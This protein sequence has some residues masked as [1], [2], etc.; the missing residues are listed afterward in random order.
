MLKV[1]AK[2]PPTSIH[3]DHGFTM[4]EVLIAIMVTTFFV[5]AALQAMAINAMF[6]VRAEQQ[7]QTN[8]WIQEDLEEVRAIAADKTTNGV[9]VNSAKCTATT[10]ASGY[11]GDLQTA[12]ND[13][14][15]SDS[16]DDTNDGNTVDDRQ[17]PAASNRQLVYQT[18]DLAR[19][20]I[21]DNTTPQVLKINYSVT[22][23]S[24]NEQIASLYAEV[25][26]SASLD[27]PP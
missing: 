3:S 4:F 20:Y 12:L 2:I 17:L 1:L 9:P 5:L 25:I 16:T 26:P 19:N 23:T 21:T 18:F 27:C 11:A 22:N 15:D 8:F 10:M 7:A 24:T 14:D 13:F 6:K